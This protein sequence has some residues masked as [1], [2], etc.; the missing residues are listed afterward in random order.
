MNSPAALPALV[1]RVGA[2]YLAG[3]DRVLPGR[4]EG[5]YLVG[6]VALGAFRPRRSDIDFVAVLSSDS[7]PSELR[8]LK[9]M[10]GRGSAL[11]VWWTLRAG[12]GRWPPTGFN[13][14]F[15]TWKDLAASPSRITP[16]ASQ[17]AG[18][19]FVGSGFDVNPVTWR[20]LGEGGIALR[21]PDPRGLRVYT[22]ERELRQWVAGNLSTYWAR[23]SDLVRGGSWTAAKGLLRTGTAWG[24]LGAPRLHATLATGEIL[25]KEQAG[26]YAMDVFASWR[27]LI[28]D[29]LAYWRGEPRSPLYKSRVRRREAAADFVGAVVAD[30]KARFRS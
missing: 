29:A 13:G 25:S 23:W 21:G 22:D 9:R 20:V 28:L 24:V 30:G 27:P 19:F 7:D 6:S 8:L 10:N 12:I 14:V 15:V 2:G 16:I 17:R 3:V 26:V 18:R 4:L 11:A 1:Q 5:F